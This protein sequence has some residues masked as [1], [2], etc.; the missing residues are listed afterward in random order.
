M[1]SKIEIETEFK[2][3]IDEKDAQGVWDF[4]SLYP[5]ELTEEEKIEYH[6]Q[7]LKFDW[8]HCHDQIVSNYQ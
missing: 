7:F 8:H 3:L 2:R 6:N 1:K 5:I 4:Y